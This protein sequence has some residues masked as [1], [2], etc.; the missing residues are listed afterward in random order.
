MILLGVA[1]SCAAVFP[2][3]IFTA[4]LKNINALS[5]FKDDGDEL[6]KFTPPPL[7]S[8]TKR[9]QSTNS[10][11]NNKRVVTNE[12][13]NVTYTTKQKVVLYITG[14]HVFRGLTMLH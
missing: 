10:T 13:M 7:A 8:E 11:V 3:N 5:I 2:V 9:Y 14:P 4:F 6:L 12:V 1:A